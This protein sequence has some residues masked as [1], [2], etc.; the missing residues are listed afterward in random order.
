MRKS[1]IKLTRCLSVA[2]GN[3]LLEPFQDKL[4]TIETPVG[5]VSGVLRRADQ[6]RH[7]VL[8]TLLIETHENWMLVK[9]WQVIKRWH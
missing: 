3:T 1:D 8:G 2:P 7:G 4:I 6:S 5:E 9:A